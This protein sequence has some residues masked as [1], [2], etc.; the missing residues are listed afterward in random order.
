MH[1]SKIMGK[2][3]HDHR[4]SRRFLLIWAWSTDYKRDYEKKKKMNRIY[5]I[6]LYFTT[7]NDENDQFFFLLIW[8]L[9][10]LNNLQ[11]FVLIVTG[12]IW[13]GLGGLISLVLIMPPN[14]FYKFCLHFVKIQKI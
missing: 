10:V 3:S 14:F 1:V 4:L 7:S 6:Y 5:N 9:I 2:L 13:G 8:K 11:I 12:K